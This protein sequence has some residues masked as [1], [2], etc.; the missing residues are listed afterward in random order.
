[1]GYP[2]LPRFWAC[3]ELDPSTGCWLW[4]FALFSEGYGAVR[5]GAKVRK[6]HVV[7]WERF[8]GPIAEA[9]E[10]DHLCRRRPCGNP[11]HLEVVTHPVNVQR[12]Y[13]ARYGPGLCRRGHPMDDSIAVV[14]QCL[15]C[16]RR[17]YH[18]SRV[19]RS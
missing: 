15:T 6:A 19:L 8:H 18:E 5:I 14:R 4:R 1:M 9:F 16:Q 2:A 11:A 13:E 12:G 10:L 7:A 17:Y 3:F